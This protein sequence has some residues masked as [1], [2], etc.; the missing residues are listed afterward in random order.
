MTDPANAASRRVLEKLGMRFE[1]IAPFE[2][3][4]AAWYALTP[5]DFVAARGEQRG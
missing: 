2:D 1:R 4:P 5:L 3:G